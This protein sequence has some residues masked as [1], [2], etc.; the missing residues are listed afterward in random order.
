VDGVA[1]DGWANRVFA[2]HDDP[3]I[4]YT[5]SDGDGS[6]Y[7]GTGRNADDNSTLSWYDCLIF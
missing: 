4:G 1:G 5:R 3:C 6:N 7:A 2:W